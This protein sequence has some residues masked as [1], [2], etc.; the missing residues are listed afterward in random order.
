MANDVKV[1]AKIWLGGWKPTYDLHKANGLTLKN[2]DTGRGF[3]FW[4]NWSQLLICCFLK[5]M[6]NQVAVQK[7]KEL[8]AHYFT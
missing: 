1:S 4:S 5:A 6:V 2:D 8:E 7:K 3:Q